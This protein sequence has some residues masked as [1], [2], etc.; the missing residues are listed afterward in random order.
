MKVRLHKSNTRLVPKWKKHGSSSSNPSRTKYRDAAKLQLLASTT[1][2]AEVPR[3]LEQ[4]DVDRVSKYSKT[5]RGTTAT[6]ASLI[7]VNARVLQV[8]TIETQFEYVYP[9]TALSR[10]YS[11]GN[12]LKMISNRCSSG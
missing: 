6:N 10:L 8:N 2:S 9:S 7:Q 4:Q 1:P 11:I 12:P 3:K 5:T